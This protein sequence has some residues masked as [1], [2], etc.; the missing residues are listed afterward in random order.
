MIFEVFQKWTNSNSKRSF[1][2]H[3]GVAP[4]VVEI[5]WI[6]VSKIVTYEEPVILLWALFYLKVY[7]P[8]VS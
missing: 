6:E 1:I 8:L 3:F 7:P 2:A 5:L 4:E